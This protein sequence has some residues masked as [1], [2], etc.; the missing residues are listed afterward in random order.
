MTSWWRLVLHWHLF[1]W[2]LAKKEEEKD[3]RLKDPDRWS[4][5]IKWKNTRCSLH[6]DRKG[7]EHHIFPLAHKDNMDLRNNLIPTKEACNG[8]ACASCMQPNPNLVT[9]SACK[10]AKYCNKVCHTLCRCYNLNKGISSIW[11]LRLGMS[12]K[13][14]ERTQ[15]RL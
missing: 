11:I 1:L 14:L 3:W 5:K 9:C 4:T 13:R 2:Q 8:A 6:W 15:S 7:N 10:R 12:K